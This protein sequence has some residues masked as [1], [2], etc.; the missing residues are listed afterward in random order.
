MGLKGASNKHSKQQPQREAIVKLMPELPFVC[1]TELPLQQLCNKQT[2]TNQLL[3]QDH[4]TN[5]M[6]I[7]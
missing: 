3:K 5:N 6:D 1:S 7:T 4:M 2:N